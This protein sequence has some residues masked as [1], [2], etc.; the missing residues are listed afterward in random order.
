MDIYL[1]AKKPLRPCT[2]PRPGPCVDA[3]RIFCHQEVRAGSAAGPIRL[4]NILQARA[5][6][7]EESIAVDEKHPIRRIW[8]KKRLNF[9]RKRRCSSKTG[10][11]M[12]HGHLVDHQHFAIMSFSVW[13]RQ[14][15]VKN[16]LVLMAFLGPKRSQAQD[17]PCVLP[18]I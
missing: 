15:F 13:Q 16:V 1:Q 18:T 9:R 10:F 17:L 5:C 8:C 7:R 3:T 14:L 6:V 11:N 2:L 12:L 4:Q